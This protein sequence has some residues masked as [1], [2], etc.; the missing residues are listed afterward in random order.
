MKQIG[1]QLGQHLTLLCHNNQKMTH[2]KLTDLTNYIHPTHLYKPTPP[3]HTP[4]N[5]NQSIIELFRHQTEL[6]QSTPTSTPKDYRC[7]K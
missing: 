1:P 6:T 2:I 5:F 3:N 7:P 4:Y